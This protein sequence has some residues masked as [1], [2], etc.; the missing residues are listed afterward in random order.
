MENITKVSVKLTNTHTMK[1]NKGEFSRYVFLQK[2][3]SGTETY[4]TDIDVKPIN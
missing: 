1:G 3:K 2:E 4:I